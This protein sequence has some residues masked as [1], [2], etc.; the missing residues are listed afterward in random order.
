MRGT[1]REMFSAAPRLPDFKKVQMIDLVRGV[2]FV[3]SMEFP[4]APEDVEAYR[5]WCVE[6]VRAAIVSQL[7]SAL[8][9]FNSPTGSAE[10]KDGP[11]GGPAGSEEVQQVSPSLSAEGLREVQ[12]VPGVPGARQDVRQQPAPAGAHEDSAGEDVVS[13]DEGSPPLVDQGGGRGAEE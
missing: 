1:S 10:G 4:M 6:V 12:D 7:N 13:Q 8:E 9:E 3:D 11:A 5:R 2:V